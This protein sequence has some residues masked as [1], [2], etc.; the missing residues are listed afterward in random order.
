MRLF[1]IK[2]SNGYFK[3]L[4]FDASTPSAK[5]SWADMLYMRK[6]PDG[7]HSASLIGETVDSDRNTL[8]L[9][10]NEQ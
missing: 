4:L 7:D 9:P 5:T 8:S 10:Q 6:K 2:K 1:Q 3:L